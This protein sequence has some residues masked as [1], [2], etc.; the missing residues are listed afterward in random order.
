[1]RDIYNTEVNQLTKEQLTTFQTIIEQANINLDKAVTL[2]GDEL[3]DR[4]NNDYF[5]LLVLKKLHQSKVNLNILLSNH[6]AEFIRDYEKVK[7][8]GFYN[9]GP[10]QGQS[11]AKMQ[12]LIGKGLIT[13]GEG[14]I[15][16]VIAT[17]PPLVCVKNF[18]RTFIV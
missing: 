18:N 6:S 2:I 12:F 13:K 10:G 11:L 14:R 17:L 3:A 7:F 16:L 1:M 8:T 15:H 9:L 4:G 5:T